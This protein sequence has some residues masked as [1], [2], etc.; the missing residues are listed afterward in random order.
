MI[1]PVVESKL[2]PTQLAA[3]TKMRIYSPEIDVE[4]L[5]RLIT[6]GIF[7]GKGVSFENLLTAA[8]IF[9]PLAVDRGKHIW[10][11]KEG[12]WL[13]D[14]KEELARRIVLCTSHRYRKD[15][16]SQVQSIVETRTPQ[17]KGLGPIDLL[18]L[19]NGMLN[20]KTMELLPHDP[21]HYS[22]YQLNLSWNPDAVCPTVDDWVGQTFDPSLHELI[23]EIMGISWHAGMG[24]QKAIVFIGGGYN[25]KGTFLRLCSA[26]LPHSAVCAIDPKYL[27][28]NRFAAAELFGKTLNVVGDIE[29]FTFNSTAE[30]KKITGEDPLHAERKM[31]HPFTFTNQATMLFSGNKMPPSRDTSHGW[32]RR[33]L[34]VPMVGEI[35]GKPNPN[36]ESQMH[37]ELEGVLVK[38]VAGLKRAKTNGTFTEPPICR[39]ALEDYEFSCNSSALFINEKLEFS[40]GFKTSLSKTSLMDAYVAF[41]RERK[42][43][44][45]SRAKFYE[46]IE[47]LGGESLEQHWVTRPSGERERAYRGVAF[48]NGMFSNF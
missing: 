36:L 42:I 47:E 41:C 10:H 23:W 8:E 6:D 17:I 31:E 37:A 28:T 38:A 25:G 30:F 45:D 35:K 15:Y 16:V 3:I 19:K 46:M 27:A 39:Q 14:G 13:S 26:P 44:A 18:N 7:I 32:F 11:Y 4:R 12:V 22:T 33:W 34:I 20:W 1:D 9:G 29:R 48:K 2:S 5:A 43:E 21:N 24:F 40:P